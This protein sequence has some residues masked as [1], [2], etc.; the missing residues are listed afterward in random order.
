ME[1]QRVLYNQLTTDTMPAKEG[2]NA[3]TQLVD[4]LARKDYTPSNVPQL[5]ERLGLPPQQQQTL[6]K[7]LKELLESGE[8]VRI[9][10]N[11]Y[12]PSNEAH[13]VAG[14]ISVNRQ[15]KGFLQPD[16]PSA[17]EIV[18]HPS[19][20][21][22]ALHGDRVVVRRE[23]KPR[24]LSPRNRADNAGAVVR[25]LERNRTLRDQRNCRSIHAQSPS[26]SLPWHSRVS[27]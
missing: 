5:L 7:A 8:V 9:K 22:T 4:L 24:G 10:G 3:G 6:Q 12:I 18:I 1:L 17:K 19:D 23:I 27:H 13:L 20:L 21:S 15:G 2:A 11:R 26:Y 14:R 16:D 25:I